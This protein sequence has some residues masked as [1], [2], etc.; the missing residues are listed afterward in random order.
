MNLGST[1][2]R[3]VRRPGAVG[4]LQGAGLVAVGLAVAGLCTYGFLGLTGRVLGAER[5]ASLSA[6]WGFVF[7][8]GPGVYAP[9][10][11]EVGRALA[12]RRAANDGGRDVVRK[13]AIA[14]GAVTVVLIVGVGL[15]GPWLRSTFF[16]GSWGMVLTLAVTLVGFFC[17][18]LARGVVSGLGRFD[19][20]AGLLGGESAMRLVIA[21]L[22]AL[23]G[24]QTAV[25]F[26]VAVAVAPFLA[27]GAAMFVGRRPRIDDGSPS[28]WRDLS[29]ALGWL[30]ASSMLSQIL[31]NAAIL[32]VRALGSDDSATAGTFLAALVIARMSL[33][34]FQAVEAALLPNLATLIAEQRVDDYRRAMRQLMSVIGGLVV[35][36]T[37][38]AFVLGP[39]VVRLLFGPGFVVSNTT[40][41]LLAAASAVYVLASAQTGAL[42]AIGGHRATAIG[43]GVACA[44][45]AVVVAVVP[46]LYLRVEL[47]YLIGSVVAAASL[48]WAMQ[49]RALAQTPPD[50]VLEEVTLLDDVVFDS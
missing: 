33:Y 1:F 8:L 40:M 47:A 31:V 2:L 25:W 39:F 6:L 9:L 38:G 29:R 14:G 44:A 41:A 30:L 34:L 11:Q 3:R 49:R 28:A 50:A 27:A 46:G 24:V 45:F 4:A 12:A 20:F 5:F 43:W 7:I 18:F 17:S 26:G 42:I 19:R 15:A 37:A 32:V 48:T 22:F 13:A 21:A 35:V 36:C 23:V 16:G 10:Q